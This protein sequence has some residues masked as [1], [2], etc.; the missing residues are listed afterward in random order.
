MVWG[1]KPECGTYNYFIPLALL[2]IRVFQGVFTNTYSL[3]VF[4][5]TRK[6]FSQRVRLGYEGFLENHQKPFR[7]VFQKTFNGFSQL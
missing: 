2:E 7:R 5:E 4:M 6:G 1:L 3:E